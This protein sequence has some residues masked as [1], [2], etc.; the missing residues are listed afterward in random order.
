VAEILARR[1][2]FAPPPESI[3]ELYHEN[4]KVNRVLGPHVLIPVEY[5]HDERAAIA[6][7]WKRYRLHPRTALPVMLT[8]ENGPLFDD[9]VAARRSE[10]DFADAELELAALGQI[11]HQ[12]Y[13][14]TGET[15]VAGGTVQKLRAAPSAGALYP[16]ELY[17]GVRRV[18]G[19]E[20]GLYHYEVEEHAL[21]LLAAGDPTD[22]LFDVCCY[23]PH[24]RTAS[25]VVLLAGAIQRTR[26][27]YGDRGY[28]YVLLDCGHLAGNLVL[29][30]T[31]L[32]LA[33]VTS[34]AFFDDAA[35]ELLRLD[36]LEEAVLY[37]AFLGPKE[38][39]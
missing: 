18:A 14:V 29:A 4:T 24:A 28:R 16:A 37:T 9:V 25:V 1:D 5:A 17:L 7:A 8:R 12:S 13:G 39:R 21:A 35:N 26:R 10:R 23:Q 22:A 11:L 31:A 2:A 30:A 15:R 27:R 32:G 34:C 38:A 20:P 33:A 6:R 19:I 3:A 36:G